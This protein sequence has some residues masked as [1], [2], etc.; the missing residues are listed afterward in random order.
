[1]AKIKRA[2]I[3]HDNADAPSAHRLARALEQAGVGVWIAPES[4]LPGE[5]WVD[6]VNRGLRECQ[7][8]VLLLTPAAVQSPWVYQ[9]MSSAIILERDGQMRILPLVAEPCPESNI[10][11][12]WRIY[13]RIEAPTYELRLNR[14][15]GILTGQDTS[16]IADEMAILNDLRQALVSLEGEDALQELLRRYPADTIHST[17][18]EWVQDVTRPA[19]ARGRAFRWMLQT[20]S[21]STEVLNRLVKDLSTEFLRE[22]IDAVATQEECQVVFTEE[23]ARQLLTN[24]RLPRTTSGAAQAI[25]VCIHCGAS[26]TSAVYLAASQH[27]AWEVKYDCVRRIIE[28]DDSDALRALRGFSTMSYWKVRSMVVDYTCR[29]YNGGRLQGESHRLAV[30]ILR[31]I[32]TDGKLAKKT[33]TAHRAK[34]LLALLQA[35]E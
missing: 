35:A 3:S 19:L 10:P 29:C 27:P 30:D 34:E 18:S 28:I 33:P 1:M 13:Q 16:E 21:V 25:K 14:L 11:P 8:L 22:F 5:N 24:P 32:L 6:A 15:I 26:Y 31:Q 2:F 9:E 17:L 23:Q 7:V 12:L 20:G 4:I